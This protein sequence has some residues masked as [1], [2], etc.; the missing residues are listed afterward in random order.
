MSPYGG[1]F[2][3]SSHGGG[4]ANNRFSFSFGAGGA[5]RSTTKESKR[6]SSRPNSVRS[7][8]ASRA[9]WRAASSMNSDRFLPSTSAARVMRSRS[10]ALMRRLTRDLRVRSVG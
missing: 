7:S 2:A 6:S 8:R 9:A 1:F 5:S 4:V 10:S 3:H